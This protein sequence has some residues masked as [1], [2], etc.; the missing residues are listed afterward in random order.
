[1]CGECGQV[2]QPVLEGGLKQRLEQMAVALVWRTGC[3]LVVWLKMVWTQQMAA[4]LVWQMG[5]G[6]VVVWLKMVST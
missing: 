2:D 5:C 1:M 3:G 6:L 4:A